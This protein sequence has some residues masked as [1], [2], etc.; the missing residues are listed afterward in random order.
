MIYVLQRPISPTPWSGTLD[1]LAIKAACLQKVGEKGPL[2]YI[3][4]HVPD[5]FLEE[6]DCLY[7][8]LYKPK[9]SRIVIIVIQQHFKQKNIRTRIFAMGY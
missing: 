8:N 6:E 9:V 3:H 1:T 5:F 4:Q 7:L 2:D